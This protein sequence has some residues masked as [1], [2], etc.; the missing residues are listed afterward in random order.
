MTSA[1]GSTSSRARFEPMKPRPPV[2]RTRLPANAGGELRAD[3]GRR[4]RGSR[5]APAS[6]ARTCG[7]GACAPGRRRRSRAARRRA[8]ASADLLDEVVLALVGNHLAAGLEQ[9]GEVRLLVRDKQRAHAGRLVQAHVVREA[10]RRADVAVERDARRG[11]AGTSRA[12]T[13]RRDTRSRAGRPAAEVVAPELEREPRGAAARAG[14]AAR[15]RA[16]SARR[17]RR[18][19]ARRRGTRRRARAGRSRCGGT[20]SRRRARGSARRSAGTT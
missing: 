17:R 14:L 4:L 2:I 3:H 11:A 1:P 5:P 16:G 12:P 10:L 15:W 20:R 19:P 8:R 18:R 13:P 9:L 6:A 7:R